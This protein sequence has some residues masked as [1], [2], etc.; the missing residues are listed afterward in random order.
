MKMRIQ[1]WMN[2]HPLSEK[3]FN[4]CSRECINPNF[5]DQY[6]Y[7]DKITEN[8]K[9]NKTSFINLNNLNRNLVHYLFN[10]LKNIF[11]ISDEEIKIIG[12][13]ISNY[14]KSFEYLHSS[15]RTI[16]IFIGKQGTAFQNSL[17]CRYIRRKYKMVHNQ[18]SRSKE[19]FTNVLISRLNQGLI[20]T[21]EF[22]YSTN[23][24]NLISMCT[25]HDKFRTI[26]SCSHSCCVLRLVHNIINN[27]P[28]VNPTPKISKKTKNIMSISKW[29]GA[30]NKKTPLQL[31]E[32][33]NGNWDN[34]E[35]VNL[36]FIAEEEEIS[37][38]NEYEYN[39]FN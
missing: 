33:L 17:Y 6:S 9:N 18:E 22:N 24:L 37:D 29:V 25:N 38:E 16:E 5:F 36:N 23:L 3:F 10:Y 14:K 28:I 35:S 20:N 2:Y 1:K 32:E 19:N 21:S 31:V 34:I 8:I 7:Y 26:N 4:D 12:G 39:E 27:G 30:W 15:R 13:G 11:Y